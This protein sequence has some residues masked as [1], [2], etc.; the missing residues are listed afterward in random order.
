MKKNFAMLFLLLLQP[1]FAVASDQ[2][3]VNGNS[4]AFQQSPYGLIF[5]R[6]IVNGESLLAMIDIGD[7]QGI[8]LSSTVAENQALPLEKTGVQVINVHGEKWDVYKGSI[9]SFSMGSK[10]ATELMFTTS[11]GEIEALSAQL[12]SEFQAVIGW[13]YFKEFV[14]E[15]DYPASV[16][17]LY[18]KLPA[19][20]RP[21]MSVKYSD[22]YGPLLFKVVLNGMSQRVMLDTGATV[23]VFDP[24]KVPFGRDNQIVFEIDNT[25]VNL[26]GYAQDLA[27]LADLGVVGVLGSDFF[28]QFNVVIDP[29]TEQMH[30]V[31]NS[32]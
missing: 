2:K 23:S 10:P 29:F 18:N 8:Q 19:S 13:G 24:A 12:D 3:D 17:R 27:V 1:W 28:N 7:Q 31:A 15:I 30:F 32:K 20:L 5:T 9:A 6:I 21:Q 26:T 4:I 22:D 16:I 25:P 14:V 11:P